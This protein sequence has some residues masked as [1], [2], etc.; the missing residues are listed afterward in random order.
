MN[1]SPEPQPIMP[2]LTRRDFVKSSSFASA[3]VALG[4]VPLFAAEEKKEGANFDSSAVLSTTRVGIIGCNVWGRDILN[5]LARLK[6]AEVV[7]ICDHYEA[8]LNRAKDLAP[9]AEAYSDYKQLLENKNVQAVIVATPSHQHK[10]IVLAALA[11]GKHV[12]CES[13]MATTIEDARAIARAARDNPR[14]YFQ[15]GQLLR[16]DPARHF[17]LQFIRSGSAGTPI[18]A[19]AQWHKKNSWRR[20]SPNAERD[21]EINWRIQKDISLGLVGEIGVQQLDVLNWMLNVKPNAVTGFGGTLFW[22]D[23]RDTDDTVQAVYEYANGM[24]VNFEATLANSFD[25]DYEVIYGSDAAVMSR[26]DKAWMFKET[27]APLLGWE[28]YARKDVF[29]NETGIA[30]VAN[31]SKSAAQGGEAGQNTVV[32]I[33]PPLEHAIKAFLIN[34]D[35]IGNAVE[36]FAATFDVKDTKALREFLAGMSKSKE[37]AAGFKEGYEAAVVA[38]KGAEA[39]ARRAR[40]LIEKDL[41]E[42]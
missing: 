32:A 23:G 1:N 16:S 28:V 7:A 22:Q 37:H 2:D 33:T 15:S 20:T 19:R 18:K 24:T 5:L 4:G 6:R 10:E 36:D 30:L 40:I 42:I 9:K 25:S 41:F 13:P 17:L 14:C 39:V 26:S 38:I 29:Y 35:L 34:A 11:A 21:K 27:D 31:A 8:T 3:M 12:Y